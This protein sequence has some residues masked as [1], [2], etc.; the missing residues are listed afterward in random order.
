MTEASTTLN[1]LEKERAWCQ[2]NLANCERDLRRVPWLLLLLVAILP[3]SWYWGLPGFVG[4]IFAVFALTGFARYLVWGHQRDYEM[5]I[6]ELDAKIGRL[7]S[8]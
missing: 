3:A 4:T 5:R 2:K 8:E 1:R 7:R 6:G